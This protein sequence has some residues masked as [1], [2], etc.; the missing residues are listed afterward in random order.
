MFAYR[1]WES[2]LLRDSTE[3]PFCFR[4]VVDIMLV[5]PN[6]NL[7]KVRPIMANAPKGADAK[8]RA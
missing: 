5:C 4:S 8:L 3:G 6:N 2:R 1:A 7:P